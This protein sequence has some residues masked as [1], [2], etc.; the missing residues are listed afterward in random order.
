[1]CKTSDECI[2][3][4]IN[5]I[6]IVVA[7]VLP[8]TRC[9]QVIPMYNCVTCVFLFGFFFALY[10]IICN[11]RRTPRLVHHALRVDTHILRCII[12]L[13]SW[14]YYYYALREYI[15]KW[16]IIKCR[17]PAVIIGMLRN[18][19]TFADFVGKIHIMRRRRCTPIIYPAFTTRIPVYN[20]PF[21]NS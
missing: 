18:V 16:I 10:I 4:I 17:R 12:T 9:I 20:I 7:V 6:R 15:K 19:L 21:A 8:Y 11:I 13:Y 1:M 5:R 2:I 14:S 3:V